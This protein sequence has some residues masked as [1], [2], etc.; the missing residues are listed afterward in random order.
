MN[1]KRKPIFFTSDW[2]IGHKNV[3]TYSNR[4]FKDVNH[5]SKVLINNYNAIVSENGLCYFLGDMGICKAETLTNV[6]SQLNGTKVLVLGNHDSRVNS[7]YTK[8]FDVVLYGARLK[9]AGEMVDLTHCPLRGVKR[10]DTSQMKGCDGS[11]NWH[12]EYKHTDFSV[13]NKGQFCL[14]G[15]IHSPNN[16]KSKKI[17]GRQYDVGVDANNYRPISI[18][19][20]ESWVAR[21]LQKNKN[22]VE[23]EK[24]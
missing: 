3:I 23:E 2:H 13:D 22:I 14:H 21:T 9:I 7:M 11:E 18:S 24:I 19:A 12:K 20:I 6:I 8:G 15:H 4:P 5:M 17:L 10:E 1:N 16:G